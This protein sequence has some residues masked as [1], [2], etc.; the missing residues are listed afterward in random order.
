MIRDECALIWDAAMTTAFPDI[1]THLS[2]LRKHC[3]TNFKLAATQFSNNLAKTR[4]IPTG[5][6]I[7][8]QILGNEDGA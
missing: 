5:S 2:A 6:Q 1:R 4:S 7:D 3:S 8:E